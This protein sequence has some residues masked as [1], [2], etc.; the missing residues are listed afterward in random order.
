[1][2]LE[3]LTATG[4]SSLG[5]ALA[6]GATL[7]ADWYTDPAVLS[8]EQERIFRRSW[9]YAGRVDQVERAGDKTQFSLLPVSVEVWGPLIFVN[10]DP[11]AAPL[12]E[13][14]RELAAIVESSG[15]DLASLRFRER[16]EWELA[17]NWKVGIENYLEC[18]HCPVAHP[19]FSDLLDVAPDAYVLRSRGSLSSQIGP[20]RPSALGRNGEDDM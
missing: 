15:L 19:S 9:Q 2:S 13:V 5:E 20:V 18:Y 4:A 12:A 6:R 3:S 14:L 16:Y 7:P 1:M 8:L 10:P 11:D 17:A